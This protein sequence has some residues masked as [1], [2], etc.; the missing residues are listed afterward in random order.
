MPP[1]EQMGTAVAVY[2][3]FGDLGVIETAYGGNTMIR[4]KN[5]Y[6]GGASPGIY[7]EGAVRNIAAF[8]EAIRAELKRSDFAFLVNTHEHVCHIG[9]NAAFADVPIVGHA[10]LRDEVL[11]VTADPGRVPKLCEKADRQVARVRDYFTKRDP[12]K[13]ESADWAVFER[14]WKTIQSDVRGNP[15]L[16]PPTMTFETEMTLHLG[17]VSVRLD[18]YGR[19]HGVADTIVR[20]PE[21]DLI[22]TAGVFYPTKVPAV[23]SVAEKGR[24]VGTPT[25]TLPWASWGRWAM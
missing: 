20:I 11:S 17:D 9:G 1:A 23:A 24:R 19:S 10:S 18:Y 14:S 2:R 8:R 7:K 3:F 5:F 22:V 12:K 25:W 4:G 16:L 13:L 6:R 21:E 15:A